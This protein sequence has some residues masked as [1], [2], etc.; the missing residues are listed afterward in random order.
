MIDS[1]WDI[2]FFKIGGISFDLNTIEHDILRKQ[3]NEPRIHFAIN[4]AS[5]SCPRLLNQAYRPETLESQ[6]DL[7]TK[8][9]IHNPIK[10]VVT[11]RELKLSKIFDWFAVDLKNAVGGVKPFIQ[12]YIDD[13]ISEAPI[14]FLNYGW[15]LNN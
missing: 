13:D 15:N 10:N 5:V 14:S 3:F 2:K 8:Y 7:Q 1:P 4:C 9:F 6:L 12:S 11:D